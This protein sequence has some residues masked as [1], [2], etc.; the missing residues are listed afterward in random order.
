MR[1]PLAAQLGALCGV[2]VVAFV[3]VCVAVTLGFGQLQ[4][5]KVARFMIDDEPRTERHSPPALTGVH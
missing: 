1:I 2:V 3:V 5:A 4:R